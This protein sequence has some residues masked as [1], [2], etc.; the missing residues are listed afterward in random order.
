MTD[1]T[2]VVF[3][4]LGPLGANNFR[5]IDRTNV[6][7]T[8]TDSSGNARTDKYACTGAS[9]I[10]PKVKTNVNDFCHVHIKGCQIMGDCY[11][12]AAGNDTPFDSWTVDGCGK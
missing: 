11:E 7:V 1:G 4:Q 3:Q 5:T 10:F 12:V 6:T 2:G 8:G 9:S